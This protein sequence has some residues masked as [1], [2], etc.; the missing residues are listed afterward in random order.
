[1]SRFDEAKRLNYIETT[2]QRMTQA[3]QQLAAFSQSVMDVYANW[4]GYVSLE[5]DPNIETRNKHGSD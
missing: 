1:M 3:S 5:T 2:E 4:Q